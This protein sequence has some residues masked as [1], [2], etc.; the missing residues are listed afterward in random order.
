MKE[1]THN[2]PEAGFIPTIV[3]LAKCPAPKDISTSQLVSSKACMVPDDRHRL[4]RLFCKYYLEIS[5]FYT[6]IALLRNTNN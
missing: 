3:T 6:I 2:S 4:F 5:F 1:T